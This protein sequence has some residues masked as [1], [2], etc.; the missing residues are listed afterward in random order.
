VDDSQA[1][2]RPPVVTISSTY[3]AGGSIVGPA[4]AD[5]LGVPFLDRAIPAAVARSLAI[6]FESAKAY[7][8]PKTKW[9]RF[10]AAFA[11]LPAGIAGPA[12][13]PAE[14][15]D[16]EDEELYKRQTEAVMRQ[17]A[18]STGG[19]FLGR[20]GMVVLADVPG[21]LHVRLDAS[22]EA[23]VAQV[24][25]LTGLPTADVARRQR[26]TDRARAVYAKRL[27]GCD[28]ADPHLY[29]LVVDTT[30]VSFQSCVALLEHALGALRAGPEDAPL[31]L[32]EPRTSTG[33]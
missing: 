7:E 9:E 5:R 25:R 14:E 32:D 3:G 4:L 33:G 27:Y 28:S 31:G 6:S 23:R 19:V 11:R 20:A 13:A 16:L 12:F 8:S 17:A 26:E 22:P 2:G 10:I 1:A 18:A 21:A 15:D 30:A 24:A 29:H